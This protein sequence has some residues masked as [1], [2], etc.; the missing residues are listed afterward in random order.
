MSRILLGISVAFLM[1]FASLSPAR[2]A[3]D[4]TKYDFG[5][6]TSVTLTTNA[7]EALAKRDYTGVAVFAKKCIELYGQKASEQQASLKNFAPSKKAFDYWALNDVG[8][9]YFILGKSYKKQG[10]PEKAKEAYKK[11]MSDY[12]FSQ[13][14]DNSSKSHWRV[15]KAA[16]DQINLLDSPYDF[17]DY[18]SE[19][20]TTKAWNGLSVKDFKAVEVF[21][22]KCID[23]YE[24]EAIKMQNSLSAFANKD[25]AFN[26]WALNDVG[27]CY[28][29]LGESLARQ[30][31]YQEAIEVYQVV[32]ENF[33]YAQCWDT[34]GWFWKP[35][36]VSRGRINKIRAEQDL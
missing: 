3:I 9:C 25:K 21:T 23:L 11:V 19:F 31:K 16:E 28:F 24:D 36:V 33:S 26:F 10:K 27:T 35:A 17:G 5:N 22:K 2:A 4:E 1:I 6:Y 15:A 29:I 30:D 32:V 7:W 34:K 13:C 14:W 8:T 12:S 18:T 20:L